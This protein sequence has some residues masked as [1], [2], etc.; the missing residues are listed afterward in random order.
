MDVDIGTSEASKPEEPREAT[1]EAPGRPEDA[2]AVAVTDVSTP[3]PQG[4]SRADDVR[5]GGTQAGDVAERLG[6]MSLEDSV[7]GIPV[8]AVGLAPE[9]VDLGATAPSATAERPP[10]PLPAATLSARLLSSGVGAAPPAPAGRPPDVAS[11]SASATQPPPDARLPDLPPSEMTAEP[12]PEPQPAAIP[13]PLPPPPPTA[14][15][16]A[17]SPGRPRP[18]SP[19]AED[20]DPPAGSVTPGPRSVSPEKARTEASSPGIVERVLSFRE[21]NPTLF[22]SSLVA[23]LAVVA[24]LIFSLYEG[25]ADAPHGPPTF[26]SHYSLLRPNPYDKLSAE[27]LE[28][29]VARLASKD[30]SPAAPGASLS[31]YY[32]IPPEWNAVLSDS[33]NVALIFGER[34]SGKSTLRILAEKHILRT[35]NL[36][37]SNE[38]GA[39]PRTATGS[40]VLLVDITPEQQSLNAF[41]PVLKAN[42]Y[43]HAATWVQKKMYTEDD[44]WNVQFHNHFRL[45]DFVDMVLGR[46][47][48]ILVDQLAQQGHARRGNSTSFLRRALGIDLGGWLLVPPLGLRTASAYELARFAGTYYMGSSDALKEMLAMVERDVEFWWGYKKFWWFLRRVFFGSGAPGAGTGIAGGV[49]EGS[50]VAFVGIVLA[51]YRFNLIFGDLFGLRRRFGWGTE[52]WGLLAFAWLVWAA[53]WVWRSRWDWV[54]GLLGA[55][56]NVGSAVTWLFHLVS[57]GAARAEPGPRAPRLSS[58][59]NIGIL[60]DD[61]RPRVIPTF[62]GREALLE[63]YVRECRRRNIRWESSVSRL[64]AFRKLVAELGYGAMV[65]LLDGIEETPLSNPLENENIVP[66]FVKTVL[67]HPLFEISMD[68][69]SGRETSFLMFFPIS[70]ASIANDEVKEMARIDK[71]TVVEIS[72]KP[73]DLLLIARRRF[74][75]YQTCSNAAPRKA[76][77]RKDAD[78]APAC[79]SS[80]FDLFCGATARDH[81]WV[82]DAVRG[83]GWI[84][85][86]R[87]MTRAMNMAVNHISKQR[88][89]GHGDE[90]FC[91]D[92]EAFRE[93]I[94]EKPIAAL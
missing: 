88:D 8:V 53:F 35:H 93:L 13:E 47:V 28:R 2:G 27:L 71:Y 90:G 65:V 94:K 64:K 23:I 4:D 11:P 46:G 3:V 56:S 85:T 10:D 44:F 54:W 19:P 24:Y 67:Q 84:R 51:A 68:K 73:A 79:R 42:L 55:V 86:P 82:L 69:E 5:S 9:P 34:G 30:P 37:S 26:Q 14:V 38:T 92:E 41:F 63:P 29:E 74:Q 31:D 18:V 57:G 17:V 43:A 70:F 77:G 81:S 83:S 75:A 50:A 61:H 48:T 15:R 72:F 45:G 66:H 25:D 59:G 12:P 87:D 49:T 52:A 91:I 62:E 20:V 80:F 58:D 16:R 89:F 76:R 6:A 60:Q 1:A 36:R 21:G 39:P 7:D 78:A 33:P 22:Y 40:G 32:Y